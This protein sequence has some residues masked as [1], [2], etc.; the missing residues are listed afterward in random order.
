MSLT[1]R[2][3]HVERNVRPCAARDLQQNTDEG[4]KRLDSWRSGHLI[5]G[6]QRAFI[7]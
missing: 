1:L 6:E 3:V 2:L 5:R 7:W 4:L